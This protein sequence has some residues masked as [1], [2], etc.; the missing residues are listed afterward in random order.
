LPCNLE[1]IESLT[2]GS[3]LIDNIDDVIYSYVDETPITSPYYYPEIL[4][5]TGMNKTHLSRTD[6]HPT[7]Q[8]V[9]YTIKGKNECLIV[10]EAYEGQTLQLIY[11]GQ[12]LDE[13]GLPALTA[14]EV[15]A[16]AYYVAFMVTQYDVFMQ[17]PGSDKILAYIKPLAEIKLCAAKTPEY[18]S[19]NFWDQL[20]AAS[21]R[22]DRK[23]F[24]SSYKLQR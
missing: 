10:D 23:Q 17:K 14:K 9:P 3:M 15:D 6:L 21:T 13:Q 19:Q 5:I 4:S 8:F 12:C 18:V 20:L 11:R 22:F 16:I 7:G 2:T 24:G 1:F